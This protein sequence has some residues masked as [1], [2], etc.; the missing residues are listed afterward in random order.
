MVPYYNVHIPTPLVGDVVTFSY[1]LH[2]RREAPVNPVIF[3]KRVDV[4]WGDIVHN[5]V[6]DKKSSEEKSTDRLF[7][8]YSASHRYT[9]YFFTFKRCVTF[10]TGE[11][12][13]FLTQPQ[14]YQDDTQMRYCN[15]VVFVGFINKNQSI[16]GEFCK[17]KEPGS[18]PGRNLVQVFI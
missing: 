16:Y 17:R 12:G 9:Y 1:E 5:F 18:S 7:F 4:N 10:L 15:F 11:R 8:I 13:F 14:R 2:S 6:R 3:K